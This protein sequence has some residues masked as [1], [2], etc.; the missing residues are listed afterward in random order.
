M[1]PVQQTGMLE[2]VERTDVC[3]LLCGCRK[4]GTES[5]CVGGWREK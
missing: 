3:L 4:D 5:L 2:L 1:E